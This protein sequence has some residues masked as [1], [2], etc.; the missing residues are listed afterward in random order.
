T[1]DLIAQYVTQ[2]RPSIETRATKPDNS[3]LLSA[4]WGDDIVEHYL[5][6]QA[7]EVRFKQA[8]IHALVLSE[9]FLYYP[10][11]PFRGPREFVPERDKETGEELVDSKG[12]PKGWMVAKGDF[13]FCNPSVFDV[14]RD[15]G[16]REWEQNRWVSIRTY[17]N[18]WEIAKRAR[19][20]A[21]SREAGDER[22]EK[23]L[24][25]SIGK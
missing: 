22:Y 15:M 9:G 8:V 11:D 10:W 23:I 3:A 6:D 16:V 1:L 7:L 17:E 4:R 14:V 12:Q 24:G 5:R 20:N 21:E 2:D 19:D 18:K 13:S 25:V